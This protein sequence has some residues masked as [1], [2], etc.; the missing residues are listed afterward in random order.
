MTVNKKPN[1]QNIKEDI[2]YTQ[3]ILEVT[4]NE[5]DRFIL[6][7]LISE[8]QE[9]LYKLESSR[10]ELELWFKH[11]VWC[12]WNKDTCPL[13]LLSAVQKQ[14]SAEPFDI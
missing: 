2:E 11:H 5:K 6:C 1:I 8:Q 3:K 13:T 10:V 14:V 12:K 9:F 4:I 7:R